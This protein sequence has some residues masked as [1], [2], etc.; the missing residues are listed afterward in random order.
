MPLPDYHG[1]SIVNLQASLITGLGGKPTGYPPLRDLPPSLVRRANKVVLLVIDGLG[2]SFLSSKKDSF[3]NKQVRGKLTSV[4]PA[5][6][7]AA[8]TSYFTGVAP[9]QHGSTGWFL[10]LKEIGQA[11]VFPPFLSRYGKHPLQSEDF[12]ISDMLGVP[13]VFA[14][15]PAT[16]LALFPE[17]LK[18]TA[19]STT[20]SQEVRRKGA[21]TLKGFFQQ[22]KTAVRA[23]DDT[24]FILAYWPTLDAL[25]HDHGMH[26]EE[27]LR[28]FEEIDAEAASLAAVIRKTGSL[29]VCSADH[30]QLDTDKQHQVLLSDH[31][32]LASCL[33]QPLCGDMR[34]AFCYVHP[35]KTGQ[36]LEYVHRHLDKQ[37]TCHPSKELVEKG[38]FGLG[39]PHPHL[40]DRIGDYTLI[41]KG[42]HVLQDVLPG[43][44]GT[45]NKG[46]H[47]GLSDEEMFVPLILID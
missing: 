2:Y 24:L 19:Y 34:C 3:L 1:G 25:G 27:V 39:K 30:G 26:S 10:Y 18:D 44:N 4:F 41:M 28:H 22:L 11:I 21:K 5:T 16:S 38:Y 43:E 12:T 35:E 29:L 6:T 14:R 33:V 37:C 8:M 15:I 7:A 23:K 32:E 45:F 20:L 9:Q 31:P 13:S 47:G 42:K 40:L 46:D 17:N 36:F